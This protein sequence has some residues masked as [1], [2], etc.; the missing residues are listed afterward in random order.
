[1]NR[2]DIKV[3]MSVPHRPDGLVKISSNVYN[4]IMP[5][6]TEQIKAQVPVRDFSSA[7]VSFHPADYASW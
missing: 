7:Q 3:T 2:M 4:S 5:L 6:V 1:M